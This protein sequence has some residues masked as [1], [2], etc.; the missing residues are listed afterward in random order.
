[1]KKDFDWRTPGLQVLGVVLFLL[2]I[3]IALEEQISYRSLIQAGFTS[4]SIWMFFLAEGN[5]TNLLHLRHEARILFWDQLESDGYC[6]A[7]IIRRSKVDRKSGLVTVQGYPAV[8][9]LLNNCTFQKKDN[10]VLLKTS[11]ESECF[12]VVW[13]LV[14]GRADGFRKQLP[15]T[16]PSC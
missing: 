9:F 7:P 10:M 2:G 11:L 16:N 6:L 4:I 14:T 12:G 8:Q 15:A 1:M 13:D 3:L 5:K